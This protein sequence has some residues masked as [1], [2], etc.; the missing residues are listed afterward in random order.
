MP[1]GKKFQPTPPEALA[2]AQAGLVMEGDLSEFG[3]LV[4]LPPLAELQ[5]KVY[6]AQH[7]EVQLDWHQGQ[8]LRRLYDTLDQGGLRLKNGRRIASNADVIRW[9][10]EAIADA[11]APCE[12]E[13]S[14]ESGLGSIGT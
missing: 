2:A 1:K 11:K 3:P 9:L 8:T 4:E 10:L 13:Q 5:P 6:I 14:D 12:L 7:V